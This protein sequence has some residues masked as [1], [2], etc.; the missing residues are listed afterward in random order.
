[1]LLRKAPSRLMASSG[2]FLSSRFH[3]RPLTQE[4]GDLNEVVDG[5]HDTAADRGRE[6]D[7]E[8]ELH[9]SLYGTRLEQ[10]AMVYPPSDVF[11]LITL[12]STT[13]RHVTDPAASPFCTD[14]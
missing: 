1:M 10:V 2:S 5:H 6:H 3:I 11:S 13:I 7:V 12:P 14:R 8:D 4:D 9:A